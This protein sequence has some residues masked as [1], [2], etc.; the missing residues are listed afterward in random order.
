M[1]ANMAASLIKHEQIVTTLPKA[2]DLRPIVEKLVTLAKRGDLHARRLAVAAAPRPR[3]RSRSSSRPSARATRTRAGGYT[4]VLKAGFRYGDNAAGGGDRVRRSRHGRQGRRGPRPARC[5][6]R[7]ASG[8]GGGVEPLP[9]DR[10]R[11]GF[12]RLF[13]WPFGG[14]AKSDQTEIGPCCALLRS[15]QFRMEMWGLVE[16]QLFL[17]L[18]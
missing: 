17:K 4:R 3:P 7:Y 8:R 9:D 12:G 1:F 16:A 13:L 6:G 15:A 18:A 10:N 2:K 11:G 5:R 14:G